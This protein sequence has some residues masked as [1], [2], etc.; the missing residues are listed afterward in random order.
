MTIHRK[1]RQLHYAIIGSFTLVFVRQLERKKKV[2]NYNVKVVYFR[3]NFKETHCDTYSR[4]Q[5]NSSISDFKSMWI[6]LHATWIK[7]N[8]Q[9][10]N[11]NQY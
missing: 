10:T 2:G 4:R 1:K 8:R 11:R 7:K 5:N 6:A 3:C 9:I